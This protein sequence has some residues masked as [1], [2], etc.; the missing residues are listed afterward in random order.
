MKYVEN[1]KNVINNL[2][3]TIDEKMTIAEA[4]LARWADKI[5]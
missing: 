3:E 1:V 4:T 2:F 5:L